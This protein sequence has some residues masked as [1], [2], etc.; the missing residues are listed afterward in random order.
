MTVKIID[1]RFNIIIYRQIDGVYMCILGP[2]LANIFV[3][4]CK[5]NFFKH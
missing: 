5:V 2:V 4:Y 1:F 3:E